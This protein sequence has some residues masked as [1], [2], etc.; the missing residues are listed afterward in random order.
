MAELHLAEN[1]V[2]LRKERKITQ[3]RLAE[4][5]GVS[6]ASVSK[7]ETGQSFP[8]IVTLPK[9]AAYFNRSIDELIGYEA[10]LDKERIRKIYFE[11]AECFATKPFEEA[12]EET[13]RW[14]KEYYSCYP[15]LLQ[16]AVLLLNHHMLVQEEKRQKEVLLKIIEVC[17][18][19]CEYSDDINLCKTA[20]N[21][22][23]VVYCILGEPDKALT[24]VGEEIEPYRNN[25]DLIVQAFQM[26]GETKKAL[27]AIQISMYQDILSV[28][29]MGA[30]YLLNTA[31]APEKT[32]EA[33]KRLQV[34]IDTF[35]IESLNPNA[36]MG[37]YYQAASILCMQ[38][39]YDQAMEMLQ[40]YAHAGNCLKENMTL[41]GD[42][43]FDQVDSWFE[44][45]DLGTKAVREKKIVL[46]SM[47]Q[48]L[49]TPA[50]AALGNRADFKILVKEIKQLVEQER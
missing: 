7:W 50:F 36:A 28:L 5:I 9:L 41:H 4:F 46:A 43:F 37:V 15:F 3:D 1:L 49:E 33:M 2:A 34:L 44:K 26:K 40:H 23:G 6:K 14:M 30:G 27:Q 19:I 25:N 24:L 12:Y 29:K 20:I 13:I 32:K 17:I 38:Q 42:A 47:W 35:E 39:E 31:S 22:E 45:F 48:A 8:D 18:R 16:I 11:L 10:Q 21:I